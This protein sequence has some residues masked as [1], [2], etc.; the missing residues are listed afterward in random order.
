M[1][2]TLIFLIGL[3]GSGKTT[4]G[5]ML[6][7]CLDYAFVDMD[8][9]IEARSGRTVPQLFEEGEP[10]FRAWEARVVEAL[11]ARERLVVATGGGVILRRE[12]VLRMKRR[13]MVIFNDRPV[14]QILSD[15]DTSGRP[16]LAGGGERL[17]AIER[18]RRALY[19]EAADRVLHNDAGP[20][21]ALEE[22]LT[23][24][25]GEKT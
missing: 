21:Q 25:E 9:E 13:G 17:Y 8:E 19:L 10:V 12:N 4:L 1:P 7:R 23:M 22:L 14:S 20:E 3:M 5:R 16:L 18:Q 15:I 6:A 2:P 24:M 11:G